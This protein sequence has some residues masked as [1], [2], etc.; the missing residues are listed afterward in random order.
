MAI[1]DAVID[2]SAVLENANI[3]RDATLDFDSDRYSPNGRVTADLDELV[4]ADADIDL[5]GANQTYFIARL[6]AARYEAHTR[7]GG[8]HVHAK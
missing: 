4:S 5:P 2:E 1:Y 8:G 7:V 6:L 3:P